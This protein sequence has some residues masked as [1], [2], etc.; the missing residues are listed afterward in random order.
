M[1]VHDFHVF[2]ALIPGKT[3]APLHVDA[4]AVLPGTVTEQCLKSITRQCLQ[5]IQGIGAIKNAKPLD[6]L[7]VKTGKPLHKFPAVELRRV[8]AFKILDH[9][10][11]TIGYGLRQP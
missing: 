3:D 1:I 9:L 11:H 6:R 7:P 5:C 2:R 10:K 4:D 8:F